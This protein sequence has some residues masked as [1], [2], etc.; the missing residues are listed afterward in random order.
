MNKHSHDK[1]CLPLSRTH[2][3]SRDTPL[4]AEAHSTPLPHTETYKAPST[5]RPHGPR[6]QPALLSPTC[7]S[8]SSTSLHCWSL[9]RPAGS[10]LCLISSQ[11][12]LVAQ[13]VKNLPAMQEI[14]V[15]KIPW[16]RAWQPTPLFLPGESQGQRSPVGFRLWGRTESDTTEA[17]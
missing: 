10:F 6:E 8:I 9:P 16:R 14:Q 11:A 5:R 15:G 17:T 7:L 1:L 12:F 4:T 13:S 2:S 3:S